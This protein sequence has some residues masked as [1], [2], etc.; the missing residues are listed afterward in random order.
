MNKQR[1]I[2]L[3]VNEHCYFIVHSV[4]RVVH[5]VNLVIHLVD[6]VVHLVDFVVHLVDF[7]IHLV[8]CVVHPID[9]VIH[10]VDCVVHLVSDLQGF[11]DR[12]PSLFH[13]QCIQLLQRILNI[14]LAEKLLQDFF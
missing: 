4:D 9:C 8:D 3:T 2:L 14:I 6:F 12:H 1:N 11:R 13:S 5:L 7:V 10:P